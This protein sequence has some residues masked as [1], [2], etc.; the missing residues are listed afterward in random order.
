MLF[1]TTVTLRLQGVRDLLTFMMQGPTWSPG[2]SVTP[3]SSVIWPTIKFPKPALIA[4]ITSP[5]EL[6]LRLQNSTCTAWLHL[7]C[8][9]VL[10]NVGQDTPQGSVRSRHCLSYYLHA[11]AAV[12]VMNRACLSKD[13]LS[14]CSPDGH[15]CPCCSNPWV[16][17]RLW[18][19]INLWLK[20]SF[21]LSSLEELAMGYEERQPLYNGLG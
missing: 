2:I 8:P 6:D 14:F 1:F 17:H 15:K 10:Q 9:G 4:L 5:E 16:L 13:L 7:V 20:I 11:T 3:G 21:R 12:S 18:G 19:K